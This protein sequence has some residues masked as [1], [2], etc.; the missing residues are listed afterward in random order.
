MKYDKNSTIADVLENS[1]EKQDI[2]SEYLNGQ[3]FGCPMSQVETL[4][5]AAE[6]HGVDLVGLLEELNQKESK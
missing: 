6:H 1:P 3:C 5:Q 4:E 2:L